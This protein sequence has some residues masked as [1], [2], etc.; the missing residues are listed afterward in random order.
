MAT[1]A[2]KSLIYAGERPDPH[3]KWV[4][5]VLVAEVSFTAWSREGSVR[6]PVYLDLRE[7]NRARSF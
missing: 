4:E 1:A 5:P 7:D 6:H 2:P 3:I